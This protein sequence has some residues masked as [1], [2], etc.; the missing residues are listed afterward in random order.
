MSTRIALTHR[1]DYRFARPTRL[2][3]HWLRLRPAP[4]CR[5]EVSSYSLKVEGGSHFINTVRDSYGNYLLRLDL[6][7]P[8]TEL[9]ITVELIAALTPC[10]PFA[11]LL[12]SAATLYPF[13]YD[14]QSQ[15]ELRAYLSSG[16]TPAT[17][18]S[19]CERL[20]REP[21]TTI[22]C[23]SRINQHISEDFARGLINEGVKAADR[24]RLIGQIPGP[25]TGPAW[26]LVEVLRALGFA[27]RFT[28]GFRVLLSDGVTAS[29]SAILHIWAE[30]F[31]PGAGWVG[32]DPSLGIFTAEAHIPLASAP[33]R[34][35]VQAVAGF[36]EACELTCR[37]VT[38]VERLTSQPQ[39][40]S[41]SAA[42][43]R[44]IQALGAR[45]DETLTQQTPGLRMGRSISFHGAD[46]GDSYAQAQALLCHI[47]ARLG[48]G[49]S[50]HLG[51]GEWY[52]GETLPRWRL[53]YYFRADGLSIS[54]A[55]LR[56]PSI[57]R[58]ELADAKSIAEELAQM[59][60]VSAEFIIPA[61]EDGL[62][63]LWQ[64]RSVCGYPPRP[65]ALSDA[66][67]R[68]RIAVLLSQAGSD[69][70]G[71]VLPLQW[72]VNAS[73]WCSGYWPFRRERLYLTPGSSPL[74]LRLPL[75]ALSLQE[76]VLADVAQ[77][78]WDESSNLLPSGQVCMEQIWSSEAC[79]QGS[80]QDRPETLGRVRE[81]TDDVSTAL[82]VTVNAPSVKVSEPNFPR[83][84]LCIEIRQ[85][86]VHVFL[87]PMLSVD[88]Y[89]SVIDSLERIAGETGFTIIP[90]GY[91]PPVDAR[92]RRWLIEPEAGAIKLTL[93]ESASWADH[94][95]HLQLAYAEAEGFGFAGSCSA[96]DGSPSLTDMRSDIFLC[97][98]TPA[99]SPF[100]TTPHLLRSLIDYWRRHPCLSY[101]FADRAIGPG[102]LAPRPDEGGDDALYELDIAL[103]RIP[104]GE[105][106]MPWLID[107][108][109]RHVL[110]DVAYD[111]HRTEIDMDC[112]YPPD[113]DQD[114]QGRISLRTFTS[115]PNAELAGLQ[116]LLLRGM[117]AYLDRHPL[118]DRGMDGK[119]IDIHDKYMLPGFLWRDLQE[120]IQDLA[121][122]GLAF[123][124]AWFEPFLALAFP[125]LGQVQF[126]DIALELRHAHEP[127]PILAE[128]PAVQGIARFV[129]TANARLQVSCSGS[130]NTTRYQLICNNAWVPLQETAVSGHYLAG[131]RYKAAQPVST[132]HPTLPVETALHFDIL[133]RWTQRTIGG[134][135]YYPPRYRNIDWRVQGAPQTTMVSGWRSGG[136]PLHGEVR[137]LSIPVP[138]SAV[139]QSR[140]GEPLQ[141]LALPESI[142]PRY[143]HLLD[144]TRV[145]VRG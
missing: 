58:P 115:P 42:D 126:G 108:L 104:A 45:I 61:Y 17:V 100:L 111:I 57:R 78:P 29:D 9:A 2:S 59:L 10:N 132:L 125:V 65:A 53:S 64:Q 73:R 74:G 11:F 54:P 8:L 4:H 103:A 39:S 128:E 66:E 36:Y 110:S 127:W 129:D 68:R 135:S 14:K 120:I 118:T 50:F 52:A 33:D 21:L 47:G 43:W 139:F 26:F 56:K 75:Q 18:K 69:P 95:A 98:A 70:T 88:H 116:S 138:E 28:S 67:S 121:T 7:E 20:D 91:E 32:L 83:T 5:E 96:A 133:D 71:F 41:Y 117:L 87:P 46:G 79:P 84:A 63:Q 102:G 60:G 145:P 23:L 51:Q 34:L 105:A 109:L 90:E 80:G 62:Q 122:V 124:P 86:A 24:S 107:R 1:I 106:A 112:L 15:R 31:L 44:A 140:G 55:P 134:C 101:F 137:I 40:A 94:Y 76:D 114:R 97:G 92:L 6:P 82:A 144:L 3:T 89:F 19:W 142:D 12:E 119:R 16:E 136:V 99:R 113:R 141:R 77:S 123:E 13:E 85:G 49:G 35:R 48:G 37:E 22:A 131:V 27:A 130:F 143:P 93:P 25:D 38:T 30:V 81:K 72:D